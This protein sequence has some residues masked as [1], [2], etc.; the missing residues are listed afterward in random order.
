MPSPEL[1][2]LSR[3]V[4]ALERQA[5]LWRAAALVG[6]VLAAVWWHA[7]APAAA[8]AGRVNTIRADRL[9][10]QDDA[11]K[12]AII[13]GVSKDARG[14][15]ILDARGKV[16]AELMLFGG[17]RGLT[18]VGEDEKAGVFIGLKEADG[19]GVAIADDSGRTRVSLG[20]VKNAP[21]LMLFDEAGK[22][23]ASL[24]LFPGPRGG[25]PAHVGLRLFNAS[26]AALGALTAGDEGSSLTLGDAGGNDRAGVLVQR[27]LATLYLKDKSGRVVFSPAKK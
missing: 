3:R 4:A 26:S 9:I 16:A 7:P 12:D 25:P 6:L 24:A 27:D 1:T 17:Q 13:L 20:L 15:R 22:M 19:P 18:V 21:S 5:R 8:Q 2:A 11:A 14:L 23:R 10:L